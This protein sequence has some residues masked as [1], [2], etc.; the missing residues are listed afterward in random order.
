MSLVVNLARGRTST[1]SGWTLGGPGRALPPHS[2]L[3][4]DGALHDAWPHTAR[5]APARCRM[6]HDALP[7]IVDQVRRGD[8]WLVVRERV[9]GPTVRRILEEMTR[10]HATLEPSW[11]LALVAPIATVLA[12][13]LR[14]RLL[15]RVGPDAIVVDVSGRVRFVGFE[16]WAPVTALRPSSAWTAL[17]APDEDSFAVVGTLFALLTG[18]SPTPE[19]E[20]LAQLQ[21]RL[22]H[23]DDAPLREALL[24]LCAK[25]LQSRPTLRHP[26]TTCAQALRQAQALADDV[27]PATLAGLVAGLFPDD[28]ERERQ[29]RDEHS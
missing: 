5:I 16:H 18:T 14:A 17:P 3:G 4:P 23:V 7:A 8:A 2:A 15:A 6:S 21:G 26:M 11:A 29:L 13:P 1:W 20:Q 25:N 12:D 9:A 27:S 19:R 28:V 24:A 22:A 10:Q